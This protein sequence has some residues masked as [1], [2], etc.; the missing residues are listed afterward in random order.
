VV[1]PALVL[2]LQNK[3]IKFAGPKSGEVEKYAQQFPLKKLASL[4]EVAETYI[5]LLVSSY[6]TGT[7]TVVDGRARLIKRKY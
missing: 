1:V 6:T 5:Y 7:C 4:E 2:P 3:H